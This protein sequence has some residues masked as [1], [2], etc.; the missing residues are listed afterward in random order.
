M[1]FSRSSIPILSRWRRL[2]HYTGKK[3]E[4]WQIYSVCENEIKAEHRRAVSPLEKV[5]EWKNGVEVKR[6]HQHLFQPAPL[7]SNVI[8]IEQK[9]G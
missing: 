3:D 7:P 1:S 2:T 8:Y 6:R 5:C 4:A 9:G